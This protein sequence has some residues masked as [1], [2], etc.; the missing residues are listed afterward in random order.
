MLNKE[1]IKAMD[2][3]AKLIEEG[4]NEKLEAM[5]KGRVDLRDQDR[6]VR[7]VKKQAAKGKTTGM[8]MMFLSNNNSVCHPSF[9]HF[10]PSENVY[11]LPLSKTIT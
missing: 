4:H 10:P 11:F 8:Y 5:E 2:G 9:K 6:Q 7:K 1:F 3:F